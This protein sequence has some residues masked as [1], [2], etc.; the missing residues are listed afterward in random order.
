MNL[1][2]RLV[3]Q[4]KL[5]RNAILLCNGK[6]IHNQRGEISEERIRKEWNLKLGAGILQNPELTL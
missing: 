4:R 6:G 5:T 3:Y 1:L 2:Q